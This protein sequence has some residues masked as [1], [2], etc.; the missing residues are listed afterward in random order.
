MQIG[1]KFGS[2]DREYLV[3][4]R[5]ALS[6][7]KGDEELSRIKKFAD[8]L[9][10]TSVQY[11]IVS[12]T[13]EATVDDFN[14]DP[15]AEPLSDELLSIQFGYQETTG[16]M[17][18]TG[19]IGNAAVFSTY[20]PVITFATSAFMALGAVLLIAGACMMNKR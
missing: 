17:T 2:L 19:G 20:N 7:Y 18:V 10:E 12:M 6:Q 15:L 16:T 4:L 13:A 9:V 1:I 14:G 5:S 3:W 11:L 8:L